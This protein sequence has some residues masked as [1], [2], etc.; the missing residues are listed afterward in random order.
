MKLLLV[1]LFLLFAF[2]HLG[3]SQ[4]FLLDEVEPSSKEYDDLIVKTNNGF[5]R[6]VSYVTKEALV[7]YRM[8]NGW[9]GIPYAKPPVGPLRFKWPEPVE[10]WF[11][12]KQT[13]A[14]PPVCYQIDSVSGEPT[15]SEDC[16]F[17]NVYAPPKSKNLAVMVLFISF[18]VCLNSF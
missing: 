1:S 16:L 6:G 13:S 15:G 11:G 18:L 7:E 12:I 5:V 14:F 9:L 3:H 17:L 4:L 8:F 10:S 2:A